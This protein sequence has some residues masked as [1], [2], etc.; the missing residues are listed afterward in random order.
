LCDDHECGVT[1]GEEEEGVERVHEPVTSF[2]KTLVAYET[3]K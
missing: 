2:A 3:A 1:S